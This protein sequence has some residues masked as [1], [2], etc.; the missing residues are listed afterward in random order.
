MSAE[1]FAKLLVIFAVVAIGWLAGRMKWLGGSDAART[2]SATA[3]YVFVPALLFR[4]TARIDFGRLEPRLLAAFFVPVLLAMAAV[5]GIERW[6]ARAGDSPAQP[7]V[8]A[9]STTFGNTVQIGIPLAAAIFGETGLAMHVTIVSLHA[10][11]IL[12]VLTALVEVDLARARHRADPGGAMLLRTMTT[13]VRNTVIHPVVLPVLAGL[14]VN[15]LG[16][17]LPSTVDDVLV[18]LGQAVVPVCL[19]LIGVSLA[20]YGVRGTVRGAAIVAAIKLLLVPLLVFV[21]AREVF[22]LSGLSLAVVVMLA[23]L[24]VGSNPLIFAQRYETLEAETSAAVVFSTVAFA[25]TGPLWLALL[26][27]WR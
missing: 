5:Y 3:F 12:T 13:T 6:R 4:T 17:T 26:A 2:I 11:T 23:A 7:S 16:L 27:A 1:V 25:L 18:V 19:I 14:A 10:L 15:A 20:A 8:R 9:I 24:P 21:V 22:A